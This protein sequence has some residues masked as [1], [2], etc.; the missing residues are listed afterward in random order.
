VYE[1]RANDP[2][3]NNIMKFME[4]TDFIPPEDWKGYKKF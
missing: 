2:L 3:S 4:K 1:K